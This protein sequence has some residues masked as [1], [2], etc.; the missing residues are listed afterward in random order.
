MSVPKTYYVYA[1]ASK[2]NGTL[3][4][5]MTNNLRRRISEHKEKS[6]PGF[7]Q[8]YNVTILV[9]FEKFDDPRYAIEREK[10][11]KGWLRKKK[12]ALI[13]SVNPEWKEIEL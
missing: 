13:E 7:T 8:K 10:V 5:G 1:L 12:I 2:R 4:I 9:Y 6:I 3:Y 11:L